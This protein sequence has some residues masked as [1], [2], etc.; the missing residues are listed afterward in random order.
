MNSQSNCLFWE[1]LFAGKRASLK[2]RFFHF[3]RKIDW[4]LF[5]E[6]S[7]AGLSPAKRCPSKGSRPPFPE[8]FMFRMVVLQNSYQLLD[9]E[10]AFQLYD[11][12]SFRQF[13]GLRESDRVPDSK[14]IWLFKNGLAASGAH[15]EVLAYWAQKGHLMDVSVQRVRKPTSLAPE[16]Y[17]TEAGKAQNTGS[18]L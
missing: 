12:L 9:N 8:L 14:I 11:R 18:N 2:S 1:E 3:S 16:D 15:L 5:E 7:K 10:M 17:E 4:P 13:V 6:P